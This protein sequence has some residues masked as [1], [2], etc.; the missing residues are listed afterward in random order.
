MQNL[1]SLPDQQILSLLAANQQY[2]SIA[3]MEC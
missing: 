2:F 1:T 3:M